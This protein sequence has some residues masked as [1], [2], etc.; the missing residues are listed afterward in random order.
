MKP[1]CNAFQL[2]LFAAIWMVLDHIDHIPGLL[3]PTAAAALHVLTRCVGPLFAFL[4]VEGFRY[5]HDRRRY[6]LRL[7]GWAAVMAAGSAA[8]NYIADDPALALHNNII[9]TLALG[10]LMLCVLAGFGRDTAVGH[11]PLRIAG[12]ALLVL[13]AAM[14]AEGGAVLLPF[15]LITYA[16]RARPTCAP[17]CT[18]GSHS[19]CL[20]WILCPIPRC[21]RRCTCW[22]SILTSC[23]CLP[24]RS[25]RAMMAPAAQAPPLPNI[26]FICSI[27]FTCGALAF[28]PCSRA[29]KKIPEAV[30]VCIASG[31]SFWNQ[32]CPDVPISIS[33]KRKIFWIDKR[34]PRLDEILPAWKVPLRRNRLPF[35]LV[36]CADS[37]P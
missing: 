19:R 17:G 1:T 34:K 18:W 6:V 29:D 12:A 20:R 2:K 27:R 10:V 23:S 25:S 8:Y 5:T 16:C 37:V 35:Y 30:P 15:M 4:A 36:L 28:W 31:F 14:C 7:F 24:C 22:P 9:L 3:P 33:L 13:A 21:M 11:R 26:S 32:P